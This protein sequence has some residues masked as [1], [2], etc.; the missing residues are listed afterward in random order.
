[1]ALKPDGQVWMVREQIIE[2][3]VSGLTIQF[4][5]VE[6]GFDDGRFRLRLF[7]DLP[8]GNREFIFDASGSEVGAGVALADLCRPS[9]LREVR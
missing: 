2:D 4:E 9:W 1:M 3:P 7:G 6:T 8:Y 5:V